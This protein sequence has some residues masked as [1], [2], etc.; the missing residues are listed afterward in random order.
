MNMIQYFM[1]NL[2]PE[3][4]FVTLKQKGWWFIIPEQ[5]HLYSPIIHAME[6]VKCESLSQISY[7][8][9]DK[10]HMFIKISDLF[11]I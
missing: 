2:L 9:Y 7:S 8:N 3:L 5:Q 4:S 6:C 11:Y 10:K 1:N